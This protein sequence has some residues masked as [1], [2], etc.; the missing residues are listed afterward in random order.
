MLI[1]QSATLVSPASGPHLPRNVTHP[2]TPIRP[3]HRPPTLH[4]P[5]TS[6]MP[7]SSSPSSHGS[8]HHTN[9]EVAIFMLRSHSCHRAPRHSPPRVA[10]AAPTS[11]ITK[12]E[13]QSSPMPPDLI[14]RCPDTHPAAPPPRAHPPPPPSCHPTPTPFSR[15]HVARSGSPWAYGRRKA[16][17]VM[18]MGGRGADA[19]SATTC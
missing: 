17:E 4:Q 13:A 16:R 12:D 14:P 10:P 11:S 7:T 1:P 2:I 19:R 8:R 9:L 18:R 5:S 6:H 3:H 15:H